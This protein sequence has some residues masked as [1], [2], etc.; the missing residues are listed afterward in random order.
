MTARSFAEV[1]KDAT[2]SSVHVATAIGNENPPLRPRRLFK[3]TTL[4]VGKFAN[5]GGRVLKPMDSERSHVPFRWNSGALAT[6]RPDQVPRFL[7]ALTDP[8]KLEVKSLPLDK[9]TAVQNRVDTAKSK[10]W[11]DGTIKSDR[12]PL[13]VK[14]NGEHLIADG[15]HRLTGAW[16]RG[17]SSANVRFKDLEPVSNTMKSDTGS[18]WSMPFDV[19]KVLP[20]QQLIFGWASV[21]EQNGVMVIDKQGD[22]IPVQELESAA[23]D[24]VLN[25]RQQGDMHDRMAVGRLVESMMF[26]TEKQAALGIDLGMQGWW[27]GFFV[28]C[29]ETWAAHKSGARPE[30]SIGGQAVPVEV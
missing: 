27:T 13:V 26:T 7:G 23:Y 17:D 3:P 11:A 19:R 14:V 16:L 24:F 2:A 8:D 22:I 1:H 9:L 4:I 12:L 15:H 6:M 10:A 30:F 18:S 29:P 21:A 25:S 28:D 5:P 20:D